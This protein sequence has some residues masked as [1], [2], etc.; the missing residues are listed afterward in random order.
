VELSFT[1]TGAKAK[2]EEDTPAGLLP[3]RAAKVQ[4]GIVWSSFVFSVLQSV[5]TFFA[6]LDGL[7]LLIGAGALAAITEAGV[8]WEPFHRDWI[9]IPMV[10]FALAG[11]LLNLVILRRIWHLRNHPA[12]QWRR[13]P[14]S[15]SK[16]RMERV[17]F[18]LS[19][20]TLVLIGLEEI[21][22]FRTFHHF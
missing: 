22:H 10:G 21:I 20:I 4:S 5:C 13:R 12:A 3:E 14:V 19:W 6:A 15:A 9:R 11:S 7:R 2:R 18:V 8:A 16:I 17:Q 1:L